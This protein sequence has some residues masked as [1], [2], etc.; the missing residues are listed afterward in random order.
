MAEIDT[1]MGMRLNK[2]IA[3]CGVCNRREA[4]SLIKGG[5]VMVNDQVIKT[6]AYLVQENEIVKYKNEIVVPLIP[7]IYVLM[8]KPKKVS[9][10][11]GEDARKSVLDIVQPK[12]DQP[13]TAVGKMDILDVGLL[14]LTNDKEVIEK[15]DLPEAEFIRVYHLS[16][17]TEISSPDLT[18]IKE[19][20]KVDNKEINILNIDF[21]DQGTKKEIGIELIQGS[22]AQI[23]SL[24]KAMDYSIEKI[25]CMNFANLTK[26][27][28]PRGWFRD[29]KPKEIVLL[30][31]FV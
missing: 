19:T 10:N 14:L 21:L 2:Y 16:L 13:L 6:P 30:K 12:Y 27:D 7:K 4:V 29:L 5:L 18:Q 1:P 17:D 3:H 20:E 24:F 11:S 28:L 31:H 9:V 25:D 15:F 22:V 23:R 26:K 8:N